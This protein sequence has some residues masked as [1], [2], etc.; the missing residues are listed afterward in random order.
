MPAIFCT[1]MSNTKITYSLHR[2]RSLPNWSMGYNSFFKKGL[3]FKDFIFYLYMHIC[4]R[5]FVCVYTPHVCRCSQG[6]KTRSDSL[7]LE[8]QQLW[9]ARGGCWERNLIPPKEQQR[10]LNTESSSP[11]M[12]VFLVFI[13]FTVHLTWVLKFWIQPSWISQ[14]CN[15]SEQFF[16]SVKVSVGSLSTFL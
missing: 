6:L 13:D 15:L 8:L 12:D 1:Y 3:L 14:S 10:L 4:V 7:G 2:W 9:V 16:F 5:V 11:S